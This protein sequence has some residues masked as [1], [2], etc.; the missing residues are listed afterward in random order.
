[1]PT[2][3][4]G[5][6]KVG[7]G[8]PMSRVSGQPYTFRFVSQNKSIS[9]GLK[10]GEALPGMYELKRTNWQCLEDTQSTL[11]LMFPE[12]IKN[13]FLSRVAVFCYM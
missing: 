4:Q 5:Q 2:R 8:F 12:R 9:Q 7:Q 6:G 10:K 3:D 13:A 1:M 11:V